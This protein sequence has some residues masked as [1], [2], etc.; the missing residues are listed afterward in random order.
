MSMVEQARSIGVSREPERE[1]LRVLF[2]GTGNPA[3]SQIAEALL[4]R[5]AAGRVT[6]A[7]AGTDPHAG[8]DPDAIDVL[9]EFGIDLRG[10]RPKPVEALADDDW[11]L[12]I[13]V[14]DRRHGSSTT[15]R[16]RPV[17]G[18]WTMPDP[19]AVEDPAER[20]QAFVDTLQYLIRRIDL[21]LAVPL[22]SL[23]RTAA[24]ERLRF[25]ERT[26]RENTHEPT[27]A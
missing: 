6:A 12:V 19:V 24:K 3:R 4:L 18:H 7:S 10:R 16:G 15:F 26:A 27:G 23:R 22:A 20:R 14:G 9:G 5:K 25:S 13:A 17:F 11:D 1:S 21:M 2:L 8:L